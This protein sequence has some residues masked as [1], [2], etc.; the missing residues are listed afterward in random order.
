MCSPYP[1]LVNRIRVILSLLIPTLAGC[2]ALV[3][4]CLPIHSI[5]AA[6]VFPPTPPPPIVLVHP[7]ALLFSLARPL[8]PIF[9]LAP[10]RLFALVPP[11]ALVRPLTLVWHLV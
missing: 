4:L 1:T 8:A 2:C 3:A 10:V 9:P 5:H 11:P 6:L 7:L